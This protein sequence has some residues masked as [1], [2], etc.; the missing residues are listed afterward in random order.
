M[1]LKKVIF[2]FIVVT[3]FTQSVS[4]TLLMFYNIYKYFLQKSAKLIH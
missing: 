1:D 4:T 3:V 2:Y